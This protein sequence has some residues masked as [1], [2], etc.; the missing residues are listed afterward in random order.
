[1]D[2][3]KWYRNRILWKAHQQKLFESN[4]NCYDGLQLLEPQKKAIFNA[5]P[6]LDVVLLFWCNENKW[7]ALGEEKIVSAYDNLLVIAELDK[8]GKEVALETS[9][10][11]SDQNVKFSAEFI[12]LNK[13]GK[14]IWAPSGASLF[15]LMNILRMFPL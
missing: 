5:I 14:K 12:Y 8:I 7:T 4:C 15:S 1:M 11:Q 3:N 2:K 9:E 10:L 6:E 13:L